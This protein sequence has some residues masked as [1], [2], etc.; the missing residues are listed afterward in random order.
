MLLLAEVSG[1]QKGMG[2][3]L[4]ISSDVLVEKIAPAAAM[5]TVRC[6]PSFLSPI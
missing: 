2:S 6:I 4:A 1:N 3:V 5:Q